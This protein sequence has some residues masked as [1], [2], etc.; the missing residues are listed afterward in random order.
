MTWERSW[1]QRNF[2]ISSVIWEKGESQNGCNNNT[3]AYQGVKNV[4][5]SENLA[6]FVFLLPPFWD[7]PFYHITDDLRDEFL[8]ADG[9]KND[10]T[11]VID[12]NGL[13][14][15]TRLL[16]KFK[17]FWAISKA[18]AWVKSF[19]CVYSSKHRLIVFEDWHLM[20]TWIQSPKHCSAGT[21]L[22]P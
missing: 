16:C 2:T 13:K 5:F 8:N 3:C 22:K 9:Y 1:S 21:Y 4:R 17:L 12:A 7:S 14:L 10:S 20:K 15:G 18:P 19:A 11:A 6:C